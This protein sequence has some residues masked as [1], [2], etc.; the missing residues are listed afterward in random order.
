MKFTTAQQ[1]EL[2]RLQNNVLASTQL[3][4]DFINYLAKEYKVKEGEEFKILPDLSGIEDKPVPSV[5]DK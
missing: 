3:R 2:V 1:Q 5:K 4:Q